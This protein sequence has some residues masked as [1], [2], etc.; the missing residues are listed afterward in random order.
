MKVLLNVIWLVFGGIELAIGYLLAALLMFVLVV[1]IP[2]G[3]QALKLAGYTLWPFGRALVSTGKGGVSKG[4]GNVL[5]FLLAGLW[6]ALGHVVA[7]AFCAITIIGLPLAA[8]HVKIA[9]AAL[10][11]FGKEIVTLDQARQRGLTPEVAVA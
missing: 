8:A 5:W 1:T 4:I 6:I 10:A 7:A 11:P 9:K 3:I 2:F